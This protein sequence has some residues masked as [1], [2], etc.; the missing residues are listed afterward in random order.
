MHT[1]VCIL[2]YLGQQD[3]AQ[4]HCP[5]SQ[6]PGAWASA[7]FQ[8]VQGVGI[9]VMLSQEKWD[10]LKG[11][12]TTCLNAFEDTISR[13]NTPIFVNKDMERGQGFLVHTAKIY[14][15]QAPYLK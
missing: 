15:M 11:I 10:K 4:K 9:F 1:V 3:A 12:I 5:Y 13:D 8:I 7:Y 6:A 2:Q 14:P